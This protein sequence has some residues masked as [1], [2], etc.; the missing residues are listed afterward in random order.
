M[1][2]QPEDDLNENN[3]PFFFSHLLR[4]SLILHVRVSIRI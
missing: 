3:V 2:N 4:E 1:P